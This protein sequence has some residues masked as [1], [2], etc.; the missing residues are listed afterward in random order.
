MDKVKV[1]LINICWRVIHRCRKPINFDSTSLLPD[2]CATSDAEN[3]DAYVERLNDLLIYRPQVKEIAI[4]APYSGG[5]SSFIL[6]YKR[7][8][9]Q[10]HYTTISLAAFKDKNET[11]YKVQEEN[12]SDDTPASQ[13]E[14]S[15]NNQVENLQN[16]EKSI[17]QQ[18]LYRA[19]TSQMPNSRFRR[20]V[21][22][23]ISDI[24]QYF[25]AVAVVLGIIC[26]L[27]LTESSFKLPPLSFPS[28]WSSINY[29]KL[30]ALVYLLVL[31]VWL[32]KV[33]ITLFSD[34][35]ISKLN[36]IKGEVAFEQKKND[37]I[38]NIYL[39]EIIYYFQ[40]TNS[41]V[42][43]FEDLDRFERTE[44]FVK[45]K[46]LNKLIND[47]NDIDDNKNPVR[48]IYALKDNVFTSN[49]R[50]KFFDA[51][52][53]VIPVTN[54]SNS[55]PK[56]KEVLKSS[57]LIDGLS[58][59]YLRDVS[60]YLDDMRMLKNIVAEY[61][62]YKPTLS[63][64]LEVDPTKLFSF[65]IYKNV[66]ADDFAELHSGSGDVAKIFN[67][68]GVFRTEHSKSI[69]VALED[70]KQKLI[71]AESELLE[72]LEELNSVCLVKVL[73]SLNLK[74]VTLL[75]RKSVLEI[76]K[77][78]VFDGLYL[79]NPKNLT[80]HFSNGQPEH[81]GESFNDIVNRVFPN[82]PPRKSA[83]HNKNKSVKSK[84]NNEVRNYSQKLSV[85]AKMSIKQLCYED[86]GAEILQG[87]KNKKLLCHLIEN[88]YIDEMYHAY[89][90]IFH[91][92]SMTRSDMNYVMSVKQ[93]VSL[94]VAYEIHNIAETLE[95]ITED[96]YIHRAFL[97]FNIIDH[98]LSV[99][100]KIP[101]KACIK[102]LQNES[103]EEVFN[104]LLQSITHLKQKEKWL[105]ELNSNWESI[106]SF[107]V[108]SE[109]TINATK[110]ILVAEI[111][112]AVHKHDVEYY[113]SFEEPSVK[114]YINKN[115]ELISYFSN[116]SLYTPA[117]LMGVRFDNIRDFVKDKNT[118]EKICFWEI[119]EVNN[120][121]LLCILA[122]LNE[123]R[124]Y[125]ACTFDDI[126]NS[127]SKDFIS[128]ISNQIEAFATI[129]LASKKLSIGSEEGALFLL[130]SNKLT[131]KIKLNI[132]AE[133]EFEI[134]SFSVINE[135]K[136]SSALISVEKVIANWENVKLLLDVCSSEKETKKNALTEVL[137]Q[138]LNAPYVYTQLN[139]SNV[140]LDELQRLELSNY[141]VDKSCELD[142]FKQLYHYV[143]FELLNSDF[144]NIEH[145]KLLV[146]ISAGEIKLNTATFDSFLSLDSFLLIKLL[147]NQY[148][149]FCTSAEFS[150]Y[151]LD[152]KDLEVLLSSDKL[153]KKQKVDAI[154]RFEEP[155]TVTPE[156]FNLL[157]D[158]ISFFN[159]PIAEYFV[160]KEIP[161]ISPALTILLLGL[162]LSIEDKLL[163]L[164]G[165]IQ[166]M[167]YDEAIEALIKVGQPYSKILSSGSYINIKPTDVN[168][169]LA[170]ALKEHRIIKSYGNSS[171]AVGEK[172]RLNVFRK[173]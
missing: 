121:N 21:I 133:E 12:S 115:N 97:N 116:D 26:F 98:L 159:E 82:F 66:Y 117:Y 13:A 61:G 161:K 71:K 83:L 30:G 49:N 145:S 154:N 52:I 129:L 157:K 18:I 140:E 72:S 127:G 44:I 162:R 69:S 11:G 106:L 17:V 46:E 107:I 137:I 22:K 40:A 3:V 153:E 93:N 63:L 41:N 78:D 150:D 91:E 114:E 55:F 9:P 122:E 143:L 132:I 4:T 10:F 125:N 141:L 168:M 64:N 86:V 7:L 39:E 24:S 128:S 23:P 1:F 15:T 45:L 76:I 43:I 147:E 50:T 67:N 54:T 73:K 110:N 37:S 173:K 87:I 170:K 84:L 85:I 135:P 163:L 74:G 172:I 152:E 19:K 6:T 77:P 62:I 25:R 123:G 88:G 20:I 104:I 169:S 158:F 112:I 2:L 70:I 164:L 108:N 105:V 33:T 68:I 171:Y 29:F 156:L 111:M 149:T 38:F 151:V 94:D 8:N 28:D 80:V 51:I 14:S 142:A 109:N 65:I 27:Y 139:K 134:E 103:E 95:F 48:F 89:I 118:A 53:P 81:L 102:C 144:S 126:L 136:L 100:N 47:S 96:Q 79:D 166:F 113:E 167:K 120:E 16:I 42:V 131:Q 165:Q 35:G 5:K 32:M 160:D 124:Q 138:Y 58:D 57:K 146:L 75:G 59:S 90:S 130:Q 119:Y 34:L 101:I 92:G 148:S 155:E 99:S 31:A 56:L 36:P 60:I